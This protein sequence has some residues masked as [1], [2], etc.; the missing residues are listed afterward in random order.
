MASWTPRLTN[1][2][3]TDGTVTSGIY[4]KTGDVVV[5][6]ADIVA[7]KSTLSADSAGFGL[8]LPVPAK[9]GT[10]WLFELNLDG[11]DA[12]PAS[13]QS[14]Q[15][16]VYAG[17]DG[18]QIDRLRIVQDVHPNTDSQYTTLTN[19]TFFE[20]SQEGYPRGEIVTVTGS[21]IAA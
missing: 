21:Y 5:F 7:K 8:T 14:G 2:K 12:D 13:L 4:S 18:S 11:R 6:T 15:G 19:L 17:S 9:S 1:V 16:L 10:R 20:G 3:G